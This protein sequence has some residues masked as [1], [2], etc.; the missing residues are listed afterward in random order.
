MIISHKLKAIFFHCRKT[1]GSSVKLNLYPYLGAD[2]LVIGGVS[3]IIGNG[4][5]INHASRQAL[6]NPF[7]AS[8]YLL[9]RARR[10]GHA[11]AANFAIKKNYR[12]IADLPE[13][14]TAKQ[15]QVAFPTEYENYFKFAFVR[16]P[17]NQVVSDYLWRRKNSSVNVSFAEYVD[18]L[19][20]KSVHPF[21]HR[22]VVRNYDIVSIDGKLICDFVGKFENLS[23]DFASVASTLGIDCRMSQVAKRGT[24]AKSSYGNFYS[25]TEREKVLK[26]FANEFSAFKYTWPFR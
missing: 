21:L 24:H 10:V 15:V 12:H 25:D 17:F 1:G 7:S 5:K 16:N 26:I 3:E 6:L 22:G 13:H 11:N 20:S 18:L 23:E 14:A 4:Y 2:D 19:E 9:Q 8:A